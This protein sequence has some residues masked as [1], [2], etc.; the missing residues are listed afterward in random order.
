MKGYSTSYQNCPKRRFDLSTKGNRMHGLLVGLVPPS[1]G[2]L[3]YLVPTKCVL[4]HSRTE[5]LAEASS[6][7]R[8]IL[9][10]HWS[11]T[12]GVLAYLT[13]SSSKHL[14]HLVF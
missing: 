9:H 10:G 1:L 7:A 6:R 12:D 11:T 5:V 2:Y 13:I 8:E 4:E 14:H 3:F